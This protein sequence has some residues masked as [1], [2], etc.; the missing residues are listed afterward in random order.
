MKLKHGYVFY[1]AC[2]RK[3]VKDHPK[4][5][6]N[7]TLQVLK[8]ELLYQTLSRL[9]SYDIVGGFVK[10][11][12]SFFSLYLIFHSVWWV[13]MIYNITWESFA[14]HPRAL[15]EFL[16]KVLTFY[17]RLMTPYFARDS[18]YYNSWCFFFYS[19]EINNLLFW[20]KYSRKEFVC[21]G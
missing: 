10:S 14:C 20:Y 7:F 16:K 8:S 9:Q 19:V 11:R 6:K 5:K 15:S 2:T 12:L 17:V 13:R 21:P 1:D 3:I 4:T 18:F